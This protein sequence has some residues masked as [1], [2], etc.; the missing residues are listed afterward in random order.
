MVIHKGIVLTNASILN[1][2]TGVYDEATSSYTPSV[3]TSSQCANEFEVQ[4]CKRAEVL[5]TIFLSVYS[6][7]Q[8]ACACFALL[9]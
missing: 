8:V 5:S 7:Q 1:T 6:L 4:V 2:A 9:S 3:K